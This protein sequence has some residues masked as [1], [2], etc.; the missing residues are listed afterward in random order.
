[1][2][3]PPCVGLLYEVLYPDLLC[4]GTPL[5]WSVIRSA[6]SGPVMWRDPSESVKYMEWSV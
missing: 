4:G 2:E 5:C 6:L 3:G 1:M